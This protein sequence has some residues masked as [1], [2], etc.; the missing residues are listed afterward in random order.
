[1]LEDSAK[2]SLMYE[3]QLFNKNVTASSFFID[4]KINSGET[5]KSDLQ[6]KYKD[7]NNSNKLHQGKQSPFKEPP[8]NSSLYININNVSRPNTQQND[9]NKSLYNSSSKKNPNNNITE[10][11]EENSPRFSRGLKLLSIKVRD[12]VYLKK[13]TS[14]NEVAE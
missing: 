7:N 10:D 9:K 11:V 14:Y 2:K 8:P 4:N 5:L 12:I 3:N 13:H 6:I 1:M